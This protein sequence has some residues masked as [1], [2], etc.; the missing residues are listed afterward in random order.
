MLGMS[1]VETKVFE[2]AHKWLEKEAMLA[3]DDE[4]RLLRRA[5]ARHIRSFASRCPFPKIL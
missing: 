4:H 3:A 2:P 1:E 5:T